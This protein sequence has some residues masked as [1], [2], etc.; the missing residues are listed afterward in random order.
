MSL[1]DCKRNFG[2]LIS[3]HQKSAREGLPLSVPR[4]SQQKTRHEDL[5]KSPVESPRATSTTSRR[6]RRLKKEREARTTD[7][8]GTT[9][10]GSPTEEITEAL[11]A[12]VCRTAQTFITL[13]AKSYSF[14]LDA[15]L[16][17]VRLSFFVLKSD[18]TVV[19][20]VICIWFNFTFLLFPLVQA[21]GLYFLFLL[22]R[23]L[24]YI[25]RISWKILDVLRSPPA[26]ILSVGHHIFHVLS[27]TPDT[28]P[29]GQ[30]GHQYAQGVTLRDQDGSPS[31]TVW[32][33]FYTAASR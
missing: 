12:I 27:T 23:V 29:T 16:T 7:I 24:H 10:V 9:L 11:L 30:P 32:D 13:L 31:A 18:V 6:R 17:T 3:R 28:E 25:F 14:L 8:S 2:L 5:A 22:L 19:F 4:N 26:P 15:A 1:D 33:E 21:F 20:K